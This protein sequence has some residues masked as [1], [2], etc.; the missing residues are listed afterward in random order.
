MQVQSSANAVKC[1]YSQVQVLCIKVQVYCSQVQVQSNQVQLQV[2]SGHV[3]VQSWVK[4]T[5]SLVIIEFNETNRITYSDHAE[6]EYQGGFS[7]KWI[8]FVWEPLEDDIVFCVMP[9][10]SREGPVIIRVARAA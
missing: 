10:D 2:Q 5:E 1:N 6:Y 9:V 8:V 3:P 4:K 7:I